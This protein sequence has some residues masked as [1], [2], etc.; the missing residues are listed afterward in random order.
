LST[1]ARRRLGATLALA[2][3]GCL[4]APAGAAE[5][6]FR[7]VFVLGAYHDGNT[8]IIGKDDTGDD[9]FTGAL[10]L[11]FE[12]ATQT[13]TW[14]LNYRPVYTAYRKNDELDYFGHSAHVG[15]SKKFSGE[16]SFNVDAAA[17][18]TDR[19]GVRPFRPDQAVNFV[20][21]NTETR[22]DVRVGGTFQAG[23][24]S[25]IDWNVGGGITTYEAADLVDNQFFGG[26]AGWRYEFSERNSLGFGVRG[27]AYLYDETPP[28]PN[29]EPPPVDTGATTA[30]VLGRHDF[31]PK[32]SL[33]YAVGATYTNSDLRSDTNMSAD[34]KYSHQPS[35]FSEL[36]AGVRQG[37]GGGTGVGGPTLDRGAYVAYKLR[38]AR[39]GLEANVLAGVWQRDGEAINGAGAARTNAWSSAE[40]IG[41]AFNRFIS[42]NVA[43]AYTNQSAHT[44]A[45]DANHSSYGMYVRWNIRGR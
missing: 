37:V 12:R 30:S 45:L 11:D 28:G 10:D 23:R 8:A 3:A 9:A 18:R 41:W 34:I 16:S 24:R 43:H 17:S 36:S 20:E 15:F 19:Q 35:E 22:A 13:T 2:T 14:T 21:R 44:D 39:S 26:G 1:D 33:Q 38:A 31:S 27:D 25:A 32:S 42:L 29:G 4:V 5:T 6:V 40:T 7:P